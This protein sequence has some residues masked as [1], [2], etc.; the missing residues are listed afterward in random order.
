MVRNT[1][2]SFGEI[3]FIMF[4]KYLARWW[5]YPGRYGEGEEEEEGLVLEYSSSWMTILPQIQYIANAPNIRRLHVHQ[6]SFEHKILCLGGVR[7]IDK[8][9]QLLIY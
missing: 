9:Y 4:E 5:G 8:T 7:Y 3:H 2:R 6:I 1:V